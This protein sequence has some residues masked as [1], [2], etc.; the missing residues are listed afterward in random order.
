MKLDQLVEEWGKDVNIDRTE[1]GDEALNI[2]KLHHK[3]R[4]L[5]IDEKLVLKNL[6]NKLKK[7]QLRKYE[8]YTQGPS[9]EDIDNGWKVP[10]RGMILKNEVS[11]YLEGDEDI[12]DIEDKI[13]MQTEKVEYLI[14][15]VDSVQKRGFL[16]KSAIEWIKFTSGG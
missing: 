5:L 15:I 12:I 1:L 13:A 10:A 16:I 9:K 2:P 11:M 6:K 8:F 7:L 4:T 3:Y 14:S